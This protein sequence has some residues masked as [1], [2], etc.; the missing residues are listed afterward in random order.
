MGALN[1]ILETEVDSILITSKTYPSGCE[2]EPT[3]FGLIV[4]CSESVN[5]PLQ[6]GRIQE[7]MM[8]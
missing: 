3:A 2:R 7:G 6:A 5:Q 8:S 4:R 1:T